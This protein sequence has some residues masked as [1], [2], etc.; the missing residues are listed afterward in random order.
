LR[1]GRAGATAK[2]LDKDAAQALQTLYKLRPVAEV[3]SK[4]A[5]A[6]L[7]FPKVVKAGLVFGGSYGE[8]V[9]IDEGQ[10]L[11]FRRRPAGPDGQ[12]E[13]RRHEDHAR[14]ALT[15]AAASWR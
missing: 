5:K 12:P 3:I 8:A 15:E 10:S 7:V 13:H 6:V 4:K 9:L 11:C 1:S 14:R 2:D